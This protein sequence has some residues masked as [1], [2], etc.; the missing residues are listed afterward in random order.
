M[1]VY[2]LIILYYV[3]CVS[4]LTNCTIVHTLLRSEKKKHSQ[5]YVNPTG[6]KHEQDVCVG[7]LL[8]TTPIL[9]VYHHIPVEFWRSDK[10]YKASLLYY[11]IS[12]HTEVHTYFMQ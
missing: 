12:L 9:S 11:T 5:Y 4:C 7:W 2:Y 10:H 6:S 3:L 1:Y 8:I